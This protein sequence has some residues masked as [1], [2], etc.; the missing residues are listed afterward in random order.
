MR[1]ASDTILVS[2]SEPGNWPH[3]R[4]KRPYP[5]FNA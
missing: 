1:K 5:S 3:N 2:P 4:R